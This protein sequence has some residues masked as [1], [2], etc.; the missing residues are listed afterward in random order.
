[1]L[2]LTY[3]SDRETNEYILIKKYFRALKQKMSII[4]NI[5]NVYKKNVN[6]V[7][8]WFVKMVIDIKENF[9]NY[10]TGLVVHISIYLMDSLIV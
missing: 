9:Y 1:M 2:K 5:K 8:K 6:S 7:L 10:I 3:T 4:L